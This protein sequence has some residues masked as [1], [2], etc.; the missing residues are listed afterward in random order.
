MLHGL[1]GS[2]ALMLLLIPTIPSPALAL[3]YILVFGFGS[4]VGMMAMSFFIGLPLHFTADR[5]NKINAGIRLLAGL[6][7]VGLGLMIVLE[8]VPVT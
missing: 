8:H 4:I 2:A 3:V 5:F 1:A 7:S 6:F